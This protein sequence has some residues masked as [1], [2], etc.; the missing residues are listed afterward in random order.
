MFDLNRFC[1]LLMLLVPI[2]DV[3]KKKLVFLFFYLNFFFIIVLEIS[4]ILFFL[5]LHWF[6]YRTLF[7]FGRCISYNHNSIHAH[8]FQ[9]D[10]PFFFFFIHLFQFWNSKS[11]QIIQVFTLHAFPFFCMHRIFIYLII[12]SSSSNSDSESMPHVPYKTNSNYFFFIGVFF[13]FAR[14]ILYTSMNYFTTLV[15]IIKY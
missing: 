5:S 2:F 3:K 9:L 7:F 4:Y 1:M 13:F 8:S 6:L 10:I 14:Y 11:N 12:S 15:A